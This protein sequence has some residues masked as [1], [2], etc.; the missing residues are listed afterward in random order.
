ML[1]ICQEEKKTEICTWL[2][3]EACSLIAKVANNEELK[4]IIVH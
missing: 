1:E 4:E 3:P 2:F